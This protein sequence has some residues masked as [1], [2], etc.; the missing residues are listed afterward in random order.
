MRSDEKAEEE[1]TILKVEA[2]LLGKIHQKGTCK[3]MLDVWELRGYNH[4]ESELV[5]RKSNLRGASSWNLFY[6]HS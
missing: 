5:K 4:P 3:R 2:Y 6:T 1:K